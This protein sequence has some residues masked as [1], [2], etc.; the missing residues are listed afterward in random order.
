[1][2]SHALAAMKAHLGSRILGFASFCF[3]W[4]FGGAPLDTRSHAPRSGPAFAF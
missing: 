1:M 4:L 2:L 3:K